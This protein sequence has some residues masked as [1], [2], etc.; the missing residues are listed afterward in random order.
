M[1]HLKLGC[2]NGCRLRLAACFGFDWDESGFDKDFVD[3]NWKQQMNWGA[4]MYLI[5]QSHKMT[6]SITDFGTA[7]ERQNERPRIEGL[8]IHCHKYK[9]YKTSSISARLS[10]SVT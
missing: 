6:K 5:G 7:L 10:S 9:I 8:S 4:S 3:T 1:R 2:I